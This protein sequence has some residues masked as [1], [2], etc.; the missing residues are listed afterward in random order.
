MNVGLFRGAA[1]LHAHQQQIESIARN[2]TNLSTVGYKRE[3]SAVRQFEVPG[4][5]GSKRGVGAEVT[6]DFSQGDLR[7]TGEVYDVALLG[8]GF[9]GVEGPA[10]EVYTRDGSFKLAPDG[11]LLTAESYPVAWTALNRQIDPRGPSPMIDGDG[12]VR[13]GGA[14]VGRLKIVDFEDNQ[15]LISD[16][17]GYW[18]APADLKEATATATVH[19]GALEESNS[20]GVVE[21]VDMI[22]VQRQF[23]SMAQTMKSIQESYRRL[24]RPV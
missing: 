11:V 24:T 23:E 9:F 21:M 1:S 22:L 10:G 20:T 16:G 7:R 19:Q 13:Q 12:N 5:Q 18:T 4:S 3:T 14:D 8:G 15:R 6:V 2:L 17:N